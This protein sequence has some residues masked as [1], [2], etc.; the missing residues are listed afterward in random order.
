MRVGEL[1]AA[2]SRSR[3]RIAPTLSA[4]LIV[5]LVPSMICFFG[6]LGYLNIR[7]ERQHLEK[8]TLAS[9]ERVSDVIKRNA[10]YYMLRNE[11]DG[12]YHLITEIGSEPGV[13]RIRII[14]Q[15]GRIS[16]S[17]DS[18][19]TDTF[20][21]KQTEACFACHSQSQPLT[22][23]DRPD[24]FRTYKV[25]NGQRVLGIINPIENS[26]DCSTAD[27]HA[28]PGSQ[29]ILGVLD[30]NLSLAA[31]DASLAEATRQTLLYTF[32]A[33]LAT[34]SLIPLFIWKVVHGRLKALEFGTER[35]ASGELGYQLSID[36]RDELARVAASFNAMSSDLRDARAEIDRGTRKLEQRVEEKTRE[37]NRAHEQMLRVEKMASIGKL[38]AVVAHEINNPLAGILTYAKLLNKQF[39]R[40]KDV[41]QAEVVSSLGLIE[42]ESR[43]CGEIVRNLMTFARSTPM[44]YEPT[45][46]NTVVDRCVQLVHHKLQLANVELHLELASDLPPVPCD[47]AQIEQVIV[48]LAMNAIDAM[49]NGGDLTIRTRRL[50]DAPEVQIEVEDNGSGIPVELLPNLFEPFFTTKERGHGLGLGLAISRNI[51]ERH[52]GKIQVDSAPGR[53][54]LFS[55][56]LPVKAANA[57]A[58]EESLAGAERR[59]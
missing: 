18:K 32:L 39:T 28:H 26:P 37:L 27:C 12:L 20:V 19:E 9:A 2:V 58:P 51:V 41:D 35:I 6:L 36:T 13:V 17:S 14:N 21:N 44:N 45:D 11:R 8:T 16:F 47:P 22:H 30:T 46:L 38:A 49:P 24:R 34:C 50:A 5:L 4:K 29:K 42:H 56:T 1:F 31:T 55:V 59:S 7:F 10:A 3:V 54:S 48:S 23:L 33:V 25:A 40:G 53:G 52:Q 57:A 43:R 15:E